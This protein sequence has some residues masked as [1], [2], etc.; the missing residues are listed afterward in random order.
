MDECKRTVWDVLNSIV[1]NVNVDERADCTDRK[2][3]EI[4]NE[5]IKEND[6]IKIYEFIDASERGGISPRHS[7]IITSF[8]EAYKEDPFRLCS[9]IADK[10]SL[11]DYWVFLDMVSDE[12]LLSFQNL[13][14]KI[15]YFSM[16]VQDK[17]S[18]GSKQ[19]IWTLQI[20]LVQL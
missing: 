11:Y 20:W 14:L 5:G 6:I 13:K 7:E 10:N 18:S 17:F 15:H 8:E 9:F 2:Y 16:N 19:I 1:I 4:L 12:M 3:F